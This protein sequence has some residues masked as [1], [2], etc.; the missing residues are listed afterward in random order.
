L[1]T[2]VRK[3]RKEIQ[4]TQAQVGNCPTWEISTT[5]LIMIHN[6]LQMDEVYDVAQKRA[7]CAEAE[8]ATTSRELATARKQLFDFRLATFY[9]VLGEKNG[10][11]SFPITHVGP[12]LDDLPPYS[13]PVG[14]HPESTIHRPSW[15]GDDIMDGMSSLTRN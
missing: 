14:Q 2:E 10:K 6:M 15:I 9:N 7:F 4:I 11:A 8:A 1:I 5:S 13:S 12:D 3:S